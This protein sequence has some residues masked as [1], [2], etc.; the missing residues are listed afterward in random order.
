MGKSISLTLLILLVI[1]WPV[2]RVRRS[3]I[4]LAA[5]LAG[6]TLRA[7]IHT[8]GADGN[9]N[10]LRADVS[11]NGRFIAFES[12]AST[13]VDGDSNG[14]SDIFV[15]DGETGVTQRV[16]VRSDGGQG[17]FASF[18]PA[19]SDDGCVVAFYSWATNLV[20][21]DN[22]NLADAFVR[23]R[24]NGTTELVSVAAGGAN[25]VTYD[26]EDPN[27]PNSELFPPDLSADGRFVV[28]RSFAGNLVAGDS[29]GVSDIFRWDRLGKV[30]QRVSLADNEDQ[31]T[32]ESS[33]PTVS[34]D[35]QRIAFK[36]SAGNLVAGD[37]GIYSDIFV[38]DMGAGT[39]RRV[40]V[41][42]GGNEG[43]GDSFEA[44]ISG[45]G[46]HVVFSSLAQNLVAGDNNFVVDI[47]LRDIQTNV[48][49]IVSVASGGAQANDWCTSAS[50]TADGRYVV[51]QSRATTL[52]PGDPDNAFDVFVRDRQASTTVRAS[53]D[54]NGS[55]GNG[56]SQRPTIA[57]NGR[58]VVF[59]STANN[60]VSSDI[61]G[62]RDVFRH[63]LVT[64]VPPPPP[65]T[66]TV[67][68][69]TGGPGSYF[70]Y[71]GANWAPNQTVEIY[72]N[73]SLV[74][75][76]VTTAAN[77]SLGFVIRTS[78]GTAPGAYFADVVQGTTR[79]TAGFI[80]DANAPIRPVSGSGP[81]IDLPGTISPY[82]EFR[83]LPVVARS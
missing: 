65:I 76:A 5:P 54:S 40:S 19:I 82:T 79:R 17:N 16:S 36:S 47:F 48:T 74:N 8:N 35:G 11:A 38:R 72:F 15:H 39:T 30:M 23:N 69:S 62:L 33:Q 3:Q 1:M 37:S 12:D 32:G 80:I 50:V 42:S 73:G 34:A 29:N 66:L 78:A 67:N 28:F 20:G 53:I 59:D 49:E 77:G 2:P 64:P 44:A 81:I 13:L 22:N 83:F 25:D 75:N 31:G 70:A 10:S 27:N 63:D 4:T 55:I 21:D 52:V 18:A 68:H 43:Q 61:N 56:S 46:R 24:C 6:P 51:F 57:A 45:D 14:V 26:P 58:F 71:S 60:L 7:S 41:T 9:G